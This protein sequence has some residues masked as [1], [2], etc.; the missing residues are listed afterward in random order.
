MKPQRTCIVC[1]NKFDKDALVRLSKKSNG[2]IEI[3]TQDG[4]GFYIC[5]S[6]QCQKNLQTKKVLNKVFR[7]N[8]E[9]STYQ[10]IIDGV[11]KHG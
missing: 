9:E 3:G 5:K 8:I 2:Q 1:K 7:K 6:E 11:K 10:Y 4:R